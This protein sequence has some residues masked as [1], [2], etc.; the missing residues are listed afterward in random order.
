MGVNDNGSIVGLDREIDKFH[1]GS[2]DKFLLHFKNNLKSRIG[3]EFYPYIN[4][5]ILVSGGLP[6]LL[7]ECKKSASGCF[8]D[9]KDFYVRTNPSTD[10][11]EGAR[12]ILYIKNNFS[13]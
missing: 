9:G 13:V 1:N 5:K 7:V 2:K 12:L 4:Q 3:E 10:K 11:L 8:L 6:V